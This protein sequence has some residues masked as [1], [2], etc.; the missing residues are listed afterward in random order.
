MFKQFSLIVCVLF[1][2]S[3]GNTSTPSVLLRKTTE[4]DG[5]VA[6]EMQN[7]NKHS[8]FIDVR[9]V[10]IDGDFYYDLR[11]ATGYEWF[12][13]NA[14]WTFSIWENGKKLSCDFGQTVLTASYL[15]RDFSEYKLD[16]KVTD[17]AMM[18]VKGYYNLM[19]NQESILP[20]FSSDD[21][22]LARDIFLIINVSPLD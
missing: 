11:A 3:C 22:V 7:I 1:F 4:L 21:T 18:N 5:R 20:I 8:V 17:E 13:E 16:M 15:T 9:P 2:F 10:F 6:F 19:A 14:T 12:D